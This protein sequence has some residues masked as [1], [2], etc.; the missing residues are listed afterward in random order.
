MGCCERVRRVQWALR[1]DRDDYRDGALGALER[2]AERNR[3]N[4]L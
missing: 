2:V 4:T 3:W 1:R